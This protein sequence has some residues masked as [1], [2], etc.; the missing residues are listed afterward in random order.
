M[1]I[2]SSV[3]VKA[4]DIL[5]LQGRTCHA[6]LHFAHM[7]ILRDTLQIFIMRTRT[8]HVRYSFGCLCH[9]SSARPSSLL[10]QLQ[11]RC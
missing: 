1:C 3:F 8:T 2:A 6:H 10:A 7:G 5:F 9:E 11:N 4:L